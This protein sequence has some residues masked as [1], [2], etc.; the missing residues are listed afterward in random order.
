MGRRLVVSDIHGEGH[1]L[2]QALAKAGYAPGVDRLFLLGDYIDR[3][4]DS[5]ATV[6]IVRALVKDGAVALKGNHDAM[7]VQASM[8]PGS[9]TFWV[10]HNGG[11]TTVRD[12]GGLPPHDVLA[13]LNELPLYYEEPDCIL[14]HAGILPG[15]PLDKQG[16]DVLCWIRGDFHQRYRGKK[17]FFG[18]TPTPHLHRE[19][20]WEPWYGEDKV[21]IDTG[22]AY[23]GNLT[24]MNIDSGETWVA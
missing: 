12:F 8:D 23:G 2:V 22:A 19:M 18:H 6:D 7:P 24:L 1:R 16:E 11:D 13:W 20:R 9:Y 21:G 4:T 10:R 3:G 15:Y 17:V 14:V 5:K